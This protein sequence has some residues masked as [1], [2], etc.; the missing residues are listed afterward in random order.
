MAPRDPSSRLGSVP[1]VVTPDGL[2]GLDPSGFVPARD[3]L[4]RHLRRQGER[5]A[6]TQA[7]ALRRPTPS[8]WALNTLARADPGRI[9]QVL[10]AAAQVGDALADGG[11]RLRAAQSAYRE[12]VEDTVAAAAAGVGVDGETNLSRMRDTLLAAGADPEVAASMAAGTLRVDHDPP[13]F[14]VGAP[15]G[16]VVERGGARRSRSAGR[17]RSIPS[18]G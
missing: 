12:V 8:V 18:T 10:V 5:E 6:A 14:A 7:A 17:R 9:E 1:D 3:A 2:Y 16:A 15:G 13:G 11:D 4:V